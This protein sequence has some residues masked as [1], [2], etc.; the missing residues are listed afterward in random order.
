[1]VVAQAALDLIAEF[2]GCLK[3]VGNSM[4][5]P[6]LDPVG[7]PTIGIGS[8]WRRDGSRVAMSDP[9]I[10]KA[11]CVALMDLEL[12]KKCEPAVDRLITVPLHSLSRGAL[13][14]FVYNCG[15]GALKGSNLRKVINAKQWSAVTAEFAKWR[16]GGGRVLPGLVR[17]RTAEAKMFMEGVALLAEG[18]VAPAQA[19]PA[20]VPNPHAPAAKALTRA[21]ARPW[22]QF[23]G[24]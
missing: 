13:I 19:A 1:M 7:I 14:S 21:P 20:L 3:P 16:M 5:A 18:A 24:W 10:S 23:W 15:E 12:T 9:A 2:E 8:I 17:R 6:Y 22:W 4:Y 11:E